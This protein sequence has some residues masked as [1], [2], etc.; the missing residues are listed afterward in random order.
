MPARKWTEQQSETFW[1]DRTW[2]IIERDDG[3]EQEVT[4]YETSVQSHERQEMESF[5]R[6]EEK[7]QNMAQSPEAET[8]CGLGESEDLLFWMTHSSWTKCQDCQSLQ[9][10]KLFPSYRKRPVV[11]PVKNC[12]CSRNRYIVPKIDEILIVLRNLSHVEIIALRPLDVHLGDYA[13][14][15]CGYRMK[16]GMFRL[17]WSKKSVLEKIAQLDVDS[18]RRC[19]AAYQFLIASDDSA[20]SSFVAKRDL[21]VRRNDK[22]NV[23]DRD[24]SCFVENCVWPHLYPVRSWCETG[25]DGSASRLSSKV[26]FM[27]KVTSCI[28]DY[29]ISFELLHFHYDLWLFKT[30]SGAVS[31]GRNR[32][33][34]PA[35]SLETKFFSGE[36]W[37][38]Q[39]RF[40]LDA[41]R[42]FGP[43]SVFITISPFEWSFPFPPWL[44]NLRKKTGKGPTQLAA[45]ETLHIV[46]VLEQVARGY[47][48]GTNTKTW[49]SN[50]F[51][52]NRVPGYR[53]INTAFYRFEFQQRGTVHLHMLVF[54]KEM[55]HI[56]LNTI[57][58]DVPWSEPEL[59]HLVHKLQP[60]DKGALPQNDGPSELL[61][62][63]GQPC[64]RLHHPA[65][66]FAANLRA[67]ISTLVPAL[68]CRM[69]VQTSDGN[70]MLLKYVTSYVAKCHDNQMTEALYSNQVNPFQAAYRHL[71][72]LTPLE[73]EMLMALTS[74]RVAYTPSR[75]KKI[76]CPLP[77]NIQDMSSHV[78][79]K[80]RKPQ[81]E[82]LSFLEWL[83]LHDES[84]P[85]APAYT[86]N[87]TLVGIKMRSA[88]TDVFF[89]QDLVMNHPH[90]DQSELIHPDHDRL[91]DAIRYF[92]SAWCMR[93]HLWQDLDAVT[94]HFQQ[95]G[96]KT[97]YVRNLV[98]HV[99]SLRDFYHL[100]QRKV[101]GLNEVPVVVSQQSDLEFDTVQ[102]A[103]LNHVT[104][105]LSMRH[106]H[107]TE[108]QQFALPVEEP[109]SCDEEETPAAE[110]EPDVP[111]RLPSSLDLDWQKFILVLGQPGTGKTH[112]VCSSVRRTLQERFK[113]AV[114]GP[115]GL[116]A[117]LYRGQ[118]ED[119]AY[120]D[121]VHAMF[122]YPVESTV[123]ATVN[124]A[125]TDYDLLLIDEVSMIPKVIFHHILRTL[126]DLPLRPVVLLCGDPQQQQ[127]I[128]KNN[129]KTVE[130]ESI[131]HDKN[132]YKMVYKYTLVTQYRCEDQAYFDILCHLRYY[133]PS[134]QFLQRLHKGK[135]L[136]ADRPANDEDIYRALLEFPGYTFLTVTRAAS[137]RVNRVAIERIFSDPP[138]D[139]IQY[140]CELPPMPV[141]RGM[142]V[143]ATQNRDK[144]NGLVNGKRATVLHVQSPTIFL[145]LPNAKIVQT[146]PVTVSKDD[147]LFTSHP[148]VP[149]YAVTITKA[150]GQT[151]AGA[152]VWLDHHLV[153]AG[154]AYVAL[155]RIRKMVDLRFMVTT[156][157]AQYKPV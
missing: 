116:I 64:L 9:A 88:T 103:V 80:A 85:N 145:R 115:T 61:D 18:R 123:A 39:H 111:E 140:D 153:P 59:A 10:N 42:Q 112:T 132:F 54:L 62:F 104:H 14:E 110:E 93:P 3:L 15:R 87:E 154:G 156:E 43:P 119:E 4:R 65:D 36:Y 86:A 92:V 148:F 130:T 98:N 58:A 129:K 8:F 56:R 24:S 113:V 46:Q 69:D 108:D 53:N 155:S 30:V 72:V 81:D 91:P 5:Q 106:S 95:E 45:L 26:A 22:F 79:Y 52:Y 118:F 139:V 78:K 19:E 70:L 150:Q 73:P 152:I 157:R 57:R 20:Y 41:V 63:D 6:F 83:R 11:K 2:H 51:N 28:A 71:R 146:Y 134:N 121:T 74:K 133:T 89:Y 13:V 114:A 50:I 127:P 21:A 120:I 122:R 99:K 12:G 7:F 143:I 77:S 16:G 101:L 126:Q 138:L 38:W 31:V 68:K 25:L 76:T 40:L 29:S 96:H 144:A 49:G 1:E 32:F 90:R 47:L 149:A 141:Y 35:K 100:W 135:V 137:N 67:Y 66:A 33:C 128:V 23:Y 125:L 48:A 55:R 27:S 151:L 84:K 107:F 97:Y 147:Q 117:A 124:W 142:Q 34:S 131:L 60:S 102:R 82:N 136:V 109:D 105:A 17:T 75:T 94:Q 37:R 44:I